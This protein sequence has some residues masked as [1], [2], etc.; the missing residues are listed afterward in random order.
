MKQGVK[1]L[2]IDRASKVLCDT[3]TSTKVTL[4]DKFGSQS[5]II[6]V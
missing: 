1:L 5:I 4:I 2:L 6:T 3:V